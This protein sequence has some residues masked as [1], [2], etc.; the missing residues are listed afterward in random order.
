L[1]RVLYYRIPR[2]AHLD[3]GALLDLLLSEEGGPVAV[4]EGRL[5]DALQDPVLEGSIS[6]ADVKAA[7]PLALALAA[8][9]LTKPLETVVGV[10]VGAVGPGLAVGGGGR[11]AP[12]MTVG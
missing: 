2:A 6:L 11:R 9:A 12:G 5:A 1:A 10:G 4:P 8:V 7:P 3:N